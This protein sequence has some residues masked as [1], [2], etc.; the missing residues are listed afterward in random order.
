VA[1]HFGARGFV[2]PCF[3]ALDQ[4]AI[5]GR[6]ICC[7]PNGHSFKWIYDFYTLFLF[8]KPVSCSDGIEFG[9]SGANYQLFSVQFPP[10]PKLAISALNDLDTI[11]EARPLAAPCALIFCNFLQNI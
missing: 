6:F 5:R 8:N 11:T 10:H 2:I 3:R 9:T 1:N 4:T 7:S